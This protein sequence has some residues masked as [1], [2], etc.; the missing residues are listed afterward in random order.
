[1]A[2]LG[3]WA[4][5]SVAL[6]A[7]V[8]GNPSGA[9]A[10]AREPA[11]SAA[12]PSADLTRM[13]RALEEQWRI[14]PVEDGILLVP[15]RPGKP[16]KGVELRSD[17]I[18]IDGVRVSGMELR[19]RLGRDADAVLAVTYLREGDLTAL[20][21]PTEARRPA[22]VPVIPEAPVAS[23]VSP[24]LP[25]RPAFD[26]RPINRRR[27]ASVRIG[28]DLVIAEDERV[29]EAAVA[30]LGSVTVNG[31][32]D[33]DVVAVG[34]SVHLGPRAEVRG[35]VTAVGG[36]VDTASGARLLGE[37]NEVAVRVPRIAIAPPH[38]PDVIRDGAWTDWRADRWLAGMSFG[39]TL[40]RMSMIALLALLFAAVAP[41]LVGRV[42]REVRE[43]PLGAAA[44]GFGG[45]VL[46]VP[47][48]ILLGVVLVITL[49]GIALLPLLPLLAGVLAI[50]W[51]AGFA[52]VARVVGEWLPGFENR[53]VASVAVGL[54]LIW[55]VPVLA[56]AAWWWSDGIVPRAFVS[57]AWA[58]EFVVW[59]VALG[60][61]TLAWWRGGRRPA[62]G[63][64]TSQAVPTTPSF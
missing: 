6:V 9:A 31:Q 54:T 30:I 4:C 16:Y 23:A 53:P 11:V 3:S 39:W 48:F 1:M 18:A 27:G 15:R 64:V 59:I 22:S 29:E 56:R 12:A 35:S 55:T 34:G 61:I 63:P 13:R 60:G 52:G 25:P 51:V 26:D 37:V 40:V 28:G 24:S 45:A 19:E 8:A 32:V 14:V 49:I 42:G 50:A 38:L 21:D 58:L 41:Q 36:T 20:A 57:A 44:V 46:L 7:L 5:V 47:G 33:G 10:Q 62:Y 43:T 2:R 17:R